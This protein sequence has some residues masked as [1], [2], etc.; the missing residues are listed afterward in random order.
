MDVNND[1][2]QENLEKLAKERGE[3]LAFLLASLNI[4]EKQKQAWIT[5]LPEMSLDQLDK[6][7]NVLEAKYLDQNSQGADQE[8]KK[9]LTK[10]QAVYDKKTEDLK[11]STLNKIKNLSD[12]LE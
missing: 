12:K 9:D 8:F 1:V 7:L 3:R 5:L 6:L 4:D 10:I 2:S 11:Q